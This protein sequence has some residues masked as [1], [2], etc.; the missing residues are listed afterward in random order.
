MHGSPTQ[1]LQPGTATAE[2]R[3]ADRRCWGSLRPPVRRPSLDPTRRSL[4]HLPRADGALGGAVGGA[5][6]KVAVPRHGR[7]RPNA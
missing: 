2:E 3:T 4:L 1:S 6:R 5:S 7:S